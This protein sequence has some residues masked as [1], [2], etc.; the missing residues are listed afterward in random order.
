MC[1]MFHSYFDSPFQTV[2][3]DTKETLEPL[4]TLFL[5]GKVIISL[6]KD[7][8]WQKHRMLT[9]WSGERS[10]IAFQIQRCQFGKVAI[11]RCYSFKR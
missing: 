6:H 9:A 8:L 2:H 1:K 10:V 5:S 7:D 3:L 4:M 11:H